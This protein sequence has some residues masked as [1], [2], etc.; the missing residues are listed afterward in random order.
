MN[1]PLATDTINAR[2][3][4]RSRDWCAPGPFALALAVLVFIPFWNVL[5]GSDTFVARDFG[6]FSYPVAFFQRQCF[7]RGELPWWNPLSCCGLP[8]LAQWNTMALYPFSLIYLLL[9]LTWSLP[10]FCLLHLYLGGLGMYFL[11]ER[12]TGSRA[13]A[14][15]AGV[16]FAFNG[17]TLNLLMWASHIGSLAWVPWVILLTEMGWREGG[18]KMVPAILAAA[19][20]ILAGGPEEVLFTWLILLGLGVMECLQETARPGFGA[21]LFPDRI[22]SRLPGGR[23]NAALRR[24]RAPQQSG[25]PLCQI[26]M[27]HARMGLGQLSCAKVPDFRLGRYGRAKQPVLDPVLLCGHRNPVPGRDGGMA[28]EDGKGVAA[29][30]FRGGQPGAGVGRQRFCLSMAEAALADAGD[31]S[32]SNQICYCHVR[33]SAVAGGLCREPLREGAPGRGAALG[34][35]KSPLP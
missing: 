10:F 25:F 13:G 17:L 34:G 5:I 28:L 35:W 7:W 21:A 4:P 31:I 32:F 12:W 22:S 11:A 6:L 16:V 33:P 30:R 3:A 9:P 27:V 1:E 19:M 18:R 15:L 2:R 26:R 14:A 20:Q 8:F 24:F 29:G 23:P